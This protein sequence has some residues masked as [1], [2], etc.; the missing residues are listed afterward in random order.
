MTMLRAKIE[1]IPASESVHITASIGSLS[2]YENCTTPGVR[3]D[4]VMVDSEKMWTLVFPYL[5]IYS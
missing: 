3:S 2:V 5:F 1:V 4:L